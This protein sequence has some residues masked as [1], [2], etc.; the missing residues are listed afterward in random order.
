MSLWSIPVMMLAGGLA[1]ALRYGATLWIP[2]KKNGFP[3][4]I[5]IANIVGSFLAGAIVALL[6][7]QVISEDLGFIVLVG[8]AGGMTTMSTFAVDTIDRFYA[9]KWKLAGVNI[10]V[11][12][13]AGI[14]AIFAG[15][16]LAGLVV[17]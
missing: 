2:A 10:V 3:L 14:L 5:L 4:G 13:L 8:F 6:A 1:A 11:T 16:F 7:K 9:G 15:I 12:T 17:H